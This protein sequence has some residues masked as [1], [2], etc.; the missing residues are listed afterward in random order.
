MASIVSMM[1]LFLNATQILHP[2]NV[3]RLKRP[4]LDPQWSRQKSVVVLADGEAVAISNIKKNNQRVILV[5][6]VFILMRSY[7]IMTC[8]TANIFNKM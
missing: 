8:T 5:I 3:G 1:S 7:V 6:F 2:G 4:E